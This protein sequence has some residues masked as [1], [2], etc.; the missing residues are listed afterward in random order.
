[1]RLVKPSLDKK[2][3]VCSEEAIRKTIDEIASKVPGLTVGEHTKFR[4]LLRE[5]ADVISVGDGDLHGT[6]TGTTS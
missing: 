6:D 4:S 5:F 3:T 2:P 1:M